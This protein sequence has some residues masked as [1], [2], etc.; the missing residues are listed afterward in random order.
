MCVW[1]VCVCWPNVGGQNSGFS[2]LGE[3][4]R[5]NEKKKQQH[6]GLFIFSTFHCDAPVFFF[7]GSNVYFHFIVSKLKENKVVLNKKIFLHFAESI[8][9]SVIC[10]CW[11]LECKVHFYE[12]SIWLKFWGQYYHQKCSHSARQKIDSM[13]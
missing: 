8:G 2:L 7:F 1:C 9:K 6:W 10:S 5:M 13:L 12:F 4:E 11:T 3:R